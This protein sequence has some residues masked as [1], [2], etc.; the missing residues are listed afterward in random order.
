[1]S[2]SN[3]RG[4]FHELLRQGARTIAAFEEGMEEARAEKDYRDFFKSYENS[5]AL[6]LCEEE[7]LLQ[8]AEQAGID[9]KDHDRNR[10]ARELFDKAGGF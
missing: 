4:F 6:T 9:T 2:T 8:S 7:L 10:I 5:Y 3:R 1:M